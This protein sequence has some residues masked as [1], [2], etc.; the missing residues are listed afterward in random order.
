[1]DECECTWRIAG[2]S[3]GSDAVGAALSRRHATLWYGSHCLAYSRMH[4]EAGN[5][6][7]QLQAVGHRLPADFEAPI[8]M[9]SDDGDATQQLIAPGSEG[10]EVV[11]RLGRA[12]FAEVARAF[13]FEAQCP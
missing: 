10:A 7:L 13:D 5:L 4:D 2:E 8:L 6:V 1:M 9:L 12:L 3:G 11:Q